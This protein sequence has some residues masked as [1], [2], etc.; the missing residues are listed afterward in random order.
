M[1]LIKEHVQ[2]KIKQPRIKQAMP[3]IN[4]WRFAPLLF[5]W[6]KVTGGYFSNQEFIPA[7]TIPS[8]KEGL[9]SRL[10]IIDI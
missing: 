3:I 5:N 6:L 10:F 4:G 1:L 7:Q 2:N 9:H 8:I